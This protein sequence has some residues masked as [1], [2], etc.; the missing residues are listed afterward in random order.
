MLKLKFKIDKY[1]LAYNFCLKN[2]GKGKKDKEWQDIQKSLNKK[3]GD[4]IAFCFFTPEYVGYNLNVIGLGK[5]NHC[6]IKEK[7]MVIDIFNEIFKTPIFEQVYNETEQYKVRVEKEWNNNSAKIF[8]LVKEI[9]D[10]EVPTKIIDVF[11]LHPDLQIGSYMGNNQIEWGNP[12]L[13]KNY[14]SIGLAHEILHVLTEKQVSWLMHALIYLA[15]DEE[16]RMRFNNSKEY[17][18]EGTKKT[19]HKKLIA[20]SRQI[21]PHWKQYLSDKKKQNIIHLYNNLNYNNL[22]KKDNIKRYR[23]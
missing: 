4:Y 14:Q 7:K 8:S 22:K 20:I 1:H 12:D 10:L 15:I 2:F 6:L 13:W 5:N 18:K 23:N 16:L 11:I 21:L 3:F 19:Y 17:F 9:T